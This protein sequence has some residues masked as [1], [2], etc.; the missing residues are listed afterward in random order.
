M[1]VNWE[2]LIVVGPWQFLIVKDPLIVIILARSMEVRLSGTGE[3]SKTSPE[4]AVPQAV[5]I[6]E[7]GIVQSAATVRKS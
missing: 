6:P 4:T 1:A 5:A 3:G 7:L 2:A